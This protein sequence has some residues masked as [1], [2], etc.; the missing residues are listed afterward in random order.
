MDV[1]KGTVTE[2]VLKFLQRTA[3]L[4]FSKN[5]YQKGPYIKED[6]IPDHNVIQ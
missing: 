4:Q 2:P 5:E 6:S 1:S 3:V